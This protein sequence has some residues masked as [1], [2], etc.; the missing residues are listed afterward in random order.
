MYQGEGTPYKR[1]QQFTTTKKSTYPTIYQSCA[2]TYAWTIPKDPIN[3][4]TF[5]AFGPFNKYCNKSSL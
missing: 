3:K 2:Q 5:K 1:A 4:K